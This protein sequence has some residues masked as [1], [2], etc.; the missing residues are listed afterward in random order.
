MIFTCVIGGERVGHEF[1]RVPTVDVAVGHVEPGN[2][3]FALLAGCHR[4]ELLVQEV[5]NGVVNRN[6]LKQEN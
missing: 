2:E 6:A 5:H 3:H 1:G 4:S